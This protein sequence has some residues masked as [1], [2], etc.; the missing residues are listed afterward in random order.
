MLSV[1]ILFHVLLM[2]FIGLAIEDDSKQERDMA[3]LGKDLW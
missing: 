2:A 1:P 3:S